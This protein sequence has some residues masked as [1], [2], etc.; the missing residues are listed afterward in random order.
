MFSS[1]ELAQILTAH[2]LYVDTNR[3]QGARANL[4]MAE[5]YGQDFSSTMLRRA[6]LDHAILR[7]VNLVQADLQQANL[8]G[9][10][11]TGPVWR[12]PISRRHECRASGSRQLTSPT[13]MSPA[14]S[15]SL[16]R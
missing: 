15:W 14:R 7:S 1:N 12:G 6:K 4:S 2:C 10:D 16:P 11:L 8:I 3:Q 5:L 13:Q 9:A